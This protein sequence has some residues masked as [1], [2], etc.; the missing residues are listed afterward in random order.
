MDSEEVLVYFSPKCHACSKLSQIL[1]MYPDTKFH[2]INVLEHKEE[3]QK[4]G[5]RY[6]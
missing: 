4:I 5:V 3:A 2:K 1:P 6:N